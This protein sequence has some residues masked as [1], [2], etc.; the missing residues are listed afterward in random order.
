MRVK[1]FLFSAFLFLLS[2]CKLQA[3]PGI[4]LNCDPKTDAS[5]GGDVTKPPPDDGGD[6]E[7][8]PPPG[9]TPTPAPVYSTGCDRGE[10]PPL[11]LD[12][13]PGWLGLRKV[14]MVPGATHT[15][16]V[17]LN[18]DTSV[19]TMSVVDRTGASQCFYH[20]A[21]YIPPADS[22]LAT[23][24]NTRILINTGAT[25]ASRPGSLLPK[26]TWKIRIKSSIDFSDCSMAYEVTAH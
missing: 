20:I 11:N 12:G 9:P 24:G 19:F 8:D 17:N 2:A 23:K 16:C 26:G 18:W 7:V 14:A 4:N 1:H 3:L 25:F 15:Y 21:E 13:F 5:C 6:G 10:L 22:G